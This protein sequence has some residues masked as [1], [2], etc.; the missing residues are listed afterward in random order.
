MNSCIIQLILCGIVP[1]DMSSIPKIPLS[2]AAH[3]LAKQY[4]A[5][6]YNRLS[7]LPVDRYLYVPVMIDQAEPPMTQN[8]L[9]R[10]LHL[11]KATIARMLQYL[12]ENGIIVRTRNKQDKR[13]HLLGLTEQGKALVARVETEVAQLNDALEQQTGL[14]INTWL[15]QTAQLQAALHTMPDTPL[16]KSF[17]HILSNHTA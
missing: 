13:E 11:D 14:D 15:M 4:V 1:I 5:V 17:H 3:T 6:L 8:C 2:K 9:A 10:E 16:H 12:E 7:D